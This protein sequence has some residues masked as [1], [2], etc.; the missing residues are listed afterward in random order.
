M[1]LYLGLKQCKE[2]GI[3]RL[4]VRWDALLIIKQLLGLWKVKKDS[5]KTWFYGIKN[6]ARDFDAI[7]F[8]HVPRE[9]NHLA[10]A[11]ASEKLQTHVMGLQI[12]HATYVGR[13]ALKDVEAF[14]DTGQ[15]LDSMTKTQ[16]RR[17]VMKARH[18]TKIGEDLMVFGKDGVLRRVPFKEEIG[19]ILH[20]CHDESGHQGKDQDVFLILRAG[21]WWPSLV[22][23]VYY[24]CKTCHPC[25]V[26]GQRRLL[27]EP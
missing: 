8:K 20:Q 16:K 26:N 5:L 27:L 19:L 23:D 10:D 4:I 1:T 14:F 25:Q 21:F 7:Q 12:P 22:R 24:W 13:E 18:Y 11:L 17:V 2:F 3:S 6:L 9:K 15:C